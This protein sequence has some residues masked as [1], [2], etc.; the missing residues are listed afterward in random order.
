MHPLDSFLMG[1]FDESIFYD[2]FN[3]FKIIAEAASVPQMSVCR[4]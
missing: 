2:K 4:E 1:I 3:L